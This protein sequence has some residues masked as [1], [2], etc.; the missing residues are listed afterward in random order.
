[1]QD[2]LKVYQRAGEPCFR[3][4]RPIRRIV[5]GAR[6]THFCSW[7]QRL[8]AADKPGAA[9]ILRGMEPRP[10]AAPI[11][12]TGPRWTEI[13]GGDGSLGTPTGSTRRAS[14]S[15][16]SRAE[17]TKRAAAT[18][19]AAARAA[20]GARSAARSAEPRASGEAG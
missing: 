10:G 2:E 20:T 6:S 19:R 14:G 11:P 9:A 15:T 3:C 12:R 4:G 18:R 16:V 13:G 17:R 1:M 8:P 7:C 5:V